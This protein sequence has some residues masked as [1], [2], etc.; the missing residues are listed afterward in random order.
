MEKKFSIPVSFKCEDKEQ[1]ERLAKEL[2]NLGYKRYM[3]YPEAKWDKDYPYLST[4]YADAEELIGIYNS[5]FEGTAK[6]YEV[7]SEELFLALASQT[8]N[9]EFFVGEYIYS[10]CSNSWTKEFNEVGNLI[11]RFIKKEEHYSLGKLSYI[12]VDKS[13]YPFYPDEKEYAICY[14]YKGRGKIIRKATKEELI[15][16]FLPKKEE[17]KMKTLPEKWAV[18]CAN[19]EVRR[20]FDKS[21]GGS[22]YI[23]GF[24]FGYLHRFNSTNEDIT[25][26][27]IGKKASFHDGYIRSGYTEISFEDFKEFILKENN[28]EKKVIGYKLKDDCTQFEKV[29]FEI[30]NLH[31]TEGNIK[32]NNSNPNINFT[33]DSKYHDWLKEAKVLDL[34]FEAVYESIKKDVQ[35]LVKASKNLVFTISKDYEGFVSTNQSSTRIRIQ[36]L[37]LIPQGLPMGDYSEYKVKFDTFNMGCITSI[38]TSGILDVLKAYDE[39]WGTFY[40]DLPF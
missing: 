24:N 19:I 1:F 4:I 20:Y 26:S 8:S 11:G 36:D 16:H 23:N 18:N 22:C 12:Q 31:S 34:W 27:D 29:A 40:Y 13:K 30:I 14:P 9:E 3:E 37:A 7:Q 21:Y 38:K 2:E 35:V 28:M 25:I 15:N 17:T 32:F 33:E 10:D 6:K 39:F 5:D